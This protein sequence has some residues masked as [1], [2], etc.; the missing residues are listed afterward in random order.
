[1]SDAPAKAT[2]KKPRAEKPPGRW[3]V[4]LLVNAE[5]MTYVG[6]TLGASPDRRLA[7]HN[8]GASRGARSTK[9]RGP[10]MLAYAEPQPDKISA[11]RREWRL[12][13]EERGLRRRIANQSRSMVGEVPV[14]PRPPAPAAVAAMPAP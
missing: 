11:L 5:G 10:W 7:E 13:N 1:M 12:K 6:A 8:R 4:Y 2:A 3:F 9:G 14:P